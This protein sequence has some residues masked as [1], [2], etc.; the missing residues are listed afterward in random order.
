MNKV[1]IGLAIF[2]SCNTFAD[3]RCDM[4]SMSYDLQYSFDKTDYFNNSSTMTDSYEECVTVALR[5]IANAN[6]YRLI[7]SKT[8]HFSYLEKGIK[9]L[10][11]ITK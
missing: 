5:E 2:M 6:Q 11:T 3:G 8:I 4:D 9:T 10:G 1:L 7:V